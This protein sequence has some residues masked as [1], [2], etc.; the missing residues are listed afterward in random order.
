MTIYIG[1]ESIISPL[2]NTA[3]ENFAALSK[4]ISGIKK[5][6]LPGFEKGVY[7]SKLTNANSTNLYDTLLIDCLNSVKSKISA[8]IF[9]SDKTLLILSTTKGD[10]KREL[11]DTIERSV[12]NLQ[13]VFF[14]KH[15][16]L[17]VSNACAS[18]VIAINTGAKYIKGGL[19]DNVIVIG[20]DIIS[21]FVLLGFQSLFAISEN[22]C[23]PFDKN[24]T[25]ITLGEGCAAVVLSNS[26]SVFKENPIQYIEGTSSNDA[27]HISGPSRTGEGLYRSVKNTME[28]AGI[29]KNEIDFICAH[30]T[31]TMYNDDMEAT[32]FDRLEMNDIPVN[33]LKG[34][35]GHTL[36]TAGVIETAIC[37]QSMKNNTL[38]KSFGFKE[39]GTEKKINI[40][41][42]NKPAKINTVL[43][44]SSGFGGCNASLILK[45]I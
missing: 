9:S 34:Y 12:L 28:L 44:T 3:E 15:T 6:E 40:I 30:G 43:K 22:P 24:R 32:A 19:Y 13:K 18:G 8:D 4:N 31:A 20:C 45:K 17:V 7:L 35:F 33:S 1:A 11:V 29:N 23:A 27:N 21:D 16:P 38:I 10:M 36:G 26:K 41:T 14:L 42:E 2:G 5:F 39:E 37:L 25:G